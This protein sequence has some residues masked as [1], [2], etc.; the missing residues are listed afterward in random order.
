MKEF[1]FRPILGDVPEDTSWWSAEDWKSH[2]EY[3]NKLK[4]EG[5]YLTEGDEITVK[6]NPYDFDKF[7]DDRPVEEK[8]KNFG[9]LIPNGSNDFDGKIKVQY[10]PDDKTKYNQ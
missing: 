9:L 5:K 4:S 10:F 8:F 3:V 6:Y 1:K 7:I 2:E